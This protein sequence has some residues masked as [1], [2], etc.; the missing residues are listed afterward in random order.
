MVVR[1]QLGIWLVLAPLSLCAAATP[2][3]SDA[4]AEVLASISTVAQN[5]TSTKYAHH[6]RIDRQKGVYEWDCSIMA[7][8]I[9]QLAA[10]RARSAVALDRPL[11]RDFYATIARADTT[12]PRGGWL[13]LHGPS[14]TV[15]G[16]V[17]AW[18]KPAIFRNRNNTGHVG[19]ILS[20]PWR[21]PQFPSV[22]LIR[23]AD[24]THELHGD[25]TR[26]VGGEGGFGTATIA[27]AVDANDVPIAY[28]WYG[29][30]QDPSTFVPTKIAFGRVFR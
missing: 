28:G 16:D 2:S 1:W 17:F 6:A 30:A 5:L 12:V 27:F 4:T 19:F 18:I 10:P 22:W 21:H 15:P 8:W 14:N 7:A 29:A 24:A 11:A 13:R 9:L 20:R 26:K 25:D 3:P 23:I